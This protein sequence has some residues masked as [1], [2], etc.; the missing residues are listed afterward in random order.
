MERPPLLFSGKLCYTVA[1]YQRERIIHHMSIN[2]DSLLN[3]IKTFTLERVLQALLLLL[4]CLI[5]IRILLRLTERLCSHPRFDP[6]IRQYLLTA[7]KVL[8]YVLTVLIVAD[9]LG[10]PM[11]SLVALFSVLGLAI[12][13]AVQDVLSNVAGGLV[14]LFSKPFQIG[15]YIETDA[16]AGTV[17]AI[18]LIHTKLDTYGGQ[19]V[20]MPNSVLSGSKITNYTQLGTRRIDHTVTASY[21]DA[22]PAVRAACLKA[23]AMTANVLDTPAPQVVVT[24]YKESSIEYHVRCWS[25]TDNFWQVYADVLENIKT[26]FDADGV[27]MTYNHLNV[28][29]VEDDTAK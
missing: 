29:I 10:I 8:L 20:M 19:R 17:V 27:T 22:I 5:V 2:L 18:D 13:L 21:D 12:S 6:R 3:S 26:C 25:T 28:H 11:T 24:N 1:K 16:C 15:D 4:I 23:V 9:S 7:L 14:I